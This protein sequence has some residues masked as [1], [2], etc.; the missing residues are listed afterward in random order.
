[1]PRCLPAVA[2]IKG[3]DIRLVILLSLNLMYLVSGRQHGLYRGTIGSGILKRRN[4]VSIAIFNNIYF[5]R[6]PLYAVAFKVSQYESSTGG[7][8][9]EILVYYG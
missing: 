6:S 2:L 9:I 1:M 5:H 8:R 7:Q 4:D 3:F